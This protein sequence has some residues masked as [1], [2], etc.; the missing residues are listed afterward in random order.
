MPEPEKGESESLYLRR[1]ISY[2]IKEGYESKRSAAIC[3]SKYR[4][5]GTEAKSPKPER[6]KLC[7]G[8]QCKLLLAHY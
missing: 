2:M 6:K 1:C 4:K 8:D 5:S 7:K 3:Y